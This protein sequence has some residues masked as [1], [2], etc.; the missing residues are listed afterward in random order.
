MLRKDR[1]KVMILGGDGMLGHAFLEGLR[2]QHEV[3][4]TVRRSQGTHVKLPGSENTADYKFDV[5]A[6]NYISIEKSIQSFSADFVINCIGLTKS[7]C[8]TKDASKA[9]YLNAL[10]P[11]M[12]LKTCQEHGAKLIQFSSDCVFSGDDGGYE[13][14]SIPDARDLYGLSKI[15]GE[16]NSAQCLTIRKSTIGLERNTSHG[17]IEWFLNTTGTI[18]GYS[19]ALYSG[20]ISAELV[21]VANFII[22]RP[23]FLSGIIHIS[24]EPIS[25]FNLL[26]KLSRMLERD[27]L[28]IEEDSLFI[29]DRSLNGNH[30]VAA[31]GYRIPSWDNM[32]QE[33]SEEIKRRR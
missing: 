29:C 17:L 20:V 11:H 25:K 6:T 8:D 15:L 13:E 12:L 2:D 32:L 27:D 7:L 26:S 4:A 31:T 24:S 9:I 16:I 14:V 21:R 5:D 23:E 28:T 3:I 1:L 30:F 33:L 19:N 10:F 22:C 18:K